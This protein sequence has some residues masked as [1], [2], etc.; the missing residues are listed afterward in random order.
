MKLESFLTRRWNILISLV[1]GLPTFGFAVYG[2]VSP[3]G[4]SRGGMITLSV[5]GALF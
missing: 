5:I 4:E 1:Q 2:L 3:L